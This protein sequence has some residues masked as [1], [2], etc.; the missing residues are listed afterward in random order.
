MTGKPAGE[1]MW[2]TSS[3]CESGA[4]LQVGTNGTSVLVRSS[5]DPD[6]ICVTLSREEWQQFIV[7]VKDGDFDNL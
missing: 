5:A 4:C 7:A 3:R 2:S 6:G 1:P